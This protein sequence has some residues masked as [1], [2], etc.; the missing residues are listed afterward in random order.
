MHPTELRKVGEDAANGKCYLWQSDPLA[1]TIMSSL[2]GH[3]KWHR[4]SFDDPRTW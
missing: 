4:L 3:A 1:L 2:L